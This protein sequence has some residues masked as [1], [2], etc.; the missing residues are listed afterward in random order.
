MLDIV[1]V[2]WLGGG[3]GGAAVIIDVGGGGTPIDMVIVGLAFDV[4]QAG[5]GTGAAIIVLGGGT[6]A[7]CDGADICMLNWELGGAT[8]CGTECGGWNCIP[9]CICCIGGGCI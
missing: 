5:G 4:L 1:V 9:P 2:G 8:G 7:T 6:G 3:G